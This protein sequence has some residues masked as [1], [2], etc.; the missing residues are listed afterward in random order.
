MDSSQSKKTPDPLA[1]R[2][3]TGPKPWATATSQSLLADARRDQPAAWVRLVNLYAPLV[4]VWCRRLGVA[5]QDIADVLQEVFAAVARSLDR[6]RKEHPADT[7]RGW[8]ATITRNKARDYHRRRGGQPV[9][10]GGTEF[11][12]RLSQVEVP[13]ME[14]ADGEAAGDEAF[15]A[16]LRQAL[17]NI[18]GEFHDRTWQAFWST[19]VEGQTAADVAAALGMQ[20]GAVRVAKS[21]VLMRLRHE[22][23]DLEG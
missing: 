15:S 2:S 11:T 7:F 10:A 5:E 23:G 20:P 6:F 1:S 9:A 19:V 12:R 4:A 14:E 18:R 16:V 3:Q 21:R 8:L 22:L 17:A 13:V